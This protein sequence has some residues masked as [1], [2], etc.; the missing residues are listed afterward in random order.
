MDTQKV[1]EWA[2]KIV[3]G[4]G[5]ILFIGI[6]IPSVRDLIGKG[7]DV[8][9]S[10]IVSIVG[11]QNFF[12]ILSAMAI[13]TAIYSSLIQKYVVDQSKMIEFQERMKIF[14][15]EMKE[16]Q[17][18]QN[19]YMLKRLEEQQAEIMQEQM[20]MMK[21]QFKPM[22][23]IV[24]VS[25]PFLMWAY[26]YIGSHEAATMIFPFWGEQLLSGRVFYLFTY[27]L[28][29]YFLSSLAF[30]QVL[31]KFLNIRAAGV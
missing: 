8:L 18:T 26:Y 12:L 20:T 28:F 23:Y 16:A 13:I 21:D 30:S 17:E 2:N 1:R 10:P 27:W 15:K 25:I 6:M 14:Q 29:W 22:L 11:D 24:L 7:M 31:R 4:L 5:L 9:M 19:T 3:L